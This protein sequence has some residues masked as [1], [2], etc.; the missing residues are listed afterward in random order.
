MHIA[1]LVAVVERVSHQ[2]RR[3]LDDLGDD[4]QGE[5][6]KAGKQDQLERPDDRV[7]A[8]RARALAGLVGR[9]EMIVQAERDPAD[10]RQD[11][12][13]EADQVEVADARPGA[14][15]VQQVDADMAVGRHGISDRQDERGAH[16]PGVEVVAPRR[17]RIEGI[18]QHDVVEHQDDQDDH[19]RSRDRP[20][21]TADAVDQHEPIRASAETWATGTP[22]DTPPM[23]STAP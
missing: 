9:H 8:A 17:R 12:Q 3:P 20:E 6:R 1:R 11:D 21:K 13:G 16:Q 22:T 14:P 15:V 7:E 19:E 10:R 2:R 4:L 18:A 23:V 5:D